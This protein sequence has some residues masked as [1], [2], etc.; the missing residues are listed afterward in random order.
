MA[1]RLLAFTH[2][3]CAGHDPIPGHPESPDRLRAVLA[4]ISGMAGAELRYAGAV[5]PEDLA[6]VHTPDYLRQLDVL[7]DTDRVV[8]I[9]P[10]AHAGPGT[11]QAARM[12]AGAACAA[13]DAVLEAPGIPAF[14]LVRPPGHHA[15]AGR[16]MGFCFYNHVAVA[17]ARALQHPDIRR[18]AICDFDV[19]H[20]NGTEAIFAGRENVA[21]FSSH[22]MPL[23]PGTGDPETTVAPNIHNL[24]LAP[25]S[26]GGAFRAGWDERL[27]PALESFAPDLIV[28]SAGFDAH[29]ADPLAQLELVEADYAWIGRRLRTLADTHARGR[30]AAVLEGGYDLDALRASVA[31]FGAGIT[32]D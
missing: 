20:G 27:F 7:A 6:R 22:Q 16:A 25:G 21:F 31:A 10:D 4:A 8:A 26:A 28:V 12:A 30:L 17:A 5:S 24:A 3:D 1:V 9:D 23:Y 29:A 18:V 15:E 11:I 32:K 14:A 19:H 13:M 2:P